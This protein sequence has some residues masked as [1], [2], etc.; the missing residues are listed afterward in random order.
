MI[1]RFVFSARFVKMACFLGA[2]SVF[3][4]AGSA[5]TMIATAKVPFEFAAAGAM[6][7]AGNYTVDV[8]DLSGVLVLRGSTGSSVALLTLASQVAAPSGTVKLVFDRRDGM[9]YLS[10]V[11]WPNHSMLIV[12]RSLHVTKA[13]VTAALR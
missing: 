11:A 2:L 10:A 6:M 9:A 4:V 12:S 7:P 3:A 8:P 5:Q 1:A 13:P